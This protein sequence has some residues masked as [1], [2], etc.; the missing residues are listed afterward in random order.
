MFDPHTFP[1]SGHCPASAVV[2]AVR[3][4]EAPLA[5]ADLP[6]ASIRFAN[7]AFLVLVG[8]DAS[9]LVGLRLVDLGASDMNAK[10]VPHA[11]RLILNR[12]DARPL[13]VALST[14][15]VTGVEGL[16][17]CLLCSLIDMSGAG[18]DDALAREAVLLAQVAAAASDLA[19]ASDVPGDEAAPGVALEAT[20]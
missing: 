3:C 9:T 20:R 6:D 12:G 5:I 14:A 4:A 19:R 11:F 13:P 2:A 1:R 15:M 10:P 16:P 7:D 17:M 8:R 18:A